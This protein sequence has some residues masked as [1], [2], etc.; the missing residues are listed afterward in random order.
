MR[1][2]RHFANAFGQRLALFAAQQLAQLLLARQDFLARLAENGMALQDAGA[3]P[4]RESRLGGGDGL[5]GFL[6]RG[7]GIDT[8]HF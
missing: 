3:R 5:L 2:A 7:A 4:G 8:H 1:R 6:G